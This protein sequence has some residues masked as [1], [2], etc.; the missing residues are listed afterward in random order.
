MHNVYIAEGEKIVDEL[1][2]AKSGLRAIYGL[3]AWIDARRDQLSN[4]SIEYHTITE[5]ELIKISTLSTPNQVLAIVDTP[6]TILPKK[7]PE[8]LYVALDNLQDPGNLGTII[9]TADWFGFKGVICSENTVDAFNPKV[10]QST[11][12]SILH[13]PIWYGDLVEAFAANAHLPV[14]AATLDGNNVFK[15]ELPKSGILLI[16]NESKGVSPELQQLASI[17]LNIPRSGKAE[18]LNAAIA[19]GILMGLLRR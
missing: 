8:G 5:G 18:S 9:R 4:Q 11:M 7:L 12:G 14:M 10:V 16:G 13:V 6:E 17:R 3:P 19:A 15:S 1:L 2:Q